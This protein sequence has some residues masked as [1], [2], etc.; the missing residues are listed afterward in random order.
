MQQATVNLFADMG[1]QATT[2]Q[3]DLNAAAQST[4]HTAPTRRITSPAPEPGLE[5]R[6]SRSPARRPT[7]A[8]ASARSRCRPTAARPGTPPTGRGSWRY[9]W[10]PGATGITTV[11]A[12]AADDSGNL[13]A[14]AAVKVDVGG[15]NCPCTLFGGA[16]SGTAIND[17]QPIE[18]GTR[19]RPDSDG[20][21]SALWYYDAT[22]GGP[23]PVGHLWSADGTR[24][25]E[26]Q[27]PAT[28]GT[29]WQRAA[30]PAHVPV[31]AGTTY[32]TSYAASDGV[33]A[34]AESF[35][36]N[37]FDAP[38]LHAAANAGVYVYGTGFPTLTFNATNYWADVEFD[39]PDAPPAGKPSTPRAAA[40]ARTAPDRPPG[41]RRSACPRLAPS[42]AGEQARR[43]PHAGQLLR[44]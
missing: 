16:F 27:F 7:S 6:S 1:V 8:G 31:S 34:A 41:A 24:L 37:P 30:L 19:F 18:V 5:R 28:A 39:R 11:M 22:A 43:D 10:T 9:D 2:R 14:A 21:V 17:G 12:R 3:P 26:V 20:W 13:G 29:G 32:V 38:P 44:R 4:D 33:Y 40:A 23:A 15:R 35:F 25:A 36:V 42:S